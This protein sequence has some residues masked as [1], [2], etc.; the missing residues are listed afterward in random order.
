MEVRKISSSSLTL[1]GMLSTS[2]FVE[3]RLRYL[4]ITMIADSFTPR[5]FPARCQELKIS[6][7][8]KIFSFYRFK[9]VLILDFGL[10]LHITPPISF[11]DYGALNMAI[12]SDYKIGQI[13]GAIK[14]VKTKG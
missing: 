14:R 12:L 4:E 5:S 10:N 1:T 9:K 13:L 3:M 7:T 2:F 6:P 8:F 11:Y